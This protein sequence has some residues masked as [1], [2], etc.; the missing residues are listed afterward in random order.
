M[1]QEL[2]EEQI[3][4]TSDLSADKKAAIR[5]ESRIAG[6]YW[7]GVEWRI[8]IEFALFATAWV[9]VIVQ[10]LRGSMPL[11]IGLI[12]N[13]ILAATFYMPMHESV[14]GNISGRVA[15]MRWLNE[16]IGKLSQPMLI[17]SHAGHRSSHMKHHAF[18]NEPGRDP[19][20]ITRGR[21]SELPVKWLAMTLLNS[22]LPLFALF[23]A[24]RR[25]L[26]KSFMT[27]GDRDPDAAKSMFRLW[28]VSTIV[29][30]VAFVAGVGPQALMLWWLPARIQMLWLMFIF[31]WYPHHPADKSGRYVDTRVAVFPG[32]G[33]LIRGHDHHALHHLYPRVAH[34]RLRALWQEMADDLVSKGV[35]S[36]GRARASTGPVIW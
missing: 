8:V 16:L 28:A 15:S 33:L 2:N 14:H 6:R 20:V 11:W 29:L 30:V 25:L 34:Y 35:R 23:P 22:F 10:G 18:T 3:D 1:T 9:V 32:S 24:L 19:D 12:L 27:R 4:R 31:A 36:E 26:P 17:M 7:G 5:A 13:T 21:M